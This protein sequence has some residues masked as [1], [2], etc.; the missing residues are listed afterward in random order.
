LAQE[1]D[2]EHVQ[3]RI[4][5]ILDSYQVPEPPKC[6][7]TGTGTGTGTGSGA[8][9]ASGA[10]KKAATSTSAS[11]TAK[12]S[13]AVGDALNRVVPVLL[14]CVRL[15]AHA[16]YSAWAGATTARVYCCDAARSHVVVLSQAGVVALV[17]AGAVARSERVAN[18]I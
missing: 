8:A 6:M 5:F 18:C 12:S 15:C 17:Q 1:V 4:K 9:T 13:S 7:G 14:S 11:M 2:L 10:N 16:P 3:A